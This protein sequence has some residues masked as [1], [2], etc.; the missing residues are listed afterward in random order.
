MLKLVLS[1]SLIVTRNYL[2]YDDV[3]GGEH[4]INFLRLE[5]VSD[6]PWMDSN[7]DES[8]SPGV[9]EPKI[10]REHKWTRTNPVNLEEP[11]Q[12]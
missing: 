11:L 3:C 7:P 10:T 2:Q 8:F 12:N 6:R 9:G 4:T 1:P 5:F